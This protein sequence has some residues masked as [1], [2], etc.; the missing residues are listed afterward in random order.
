MER[1]VKK[2]KTDCYYICEFANLRICEFANNELDGEGKVQWK[3]S[4]LW[5]KI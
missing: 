5:R 4:A 3:N 2:K 1:Q